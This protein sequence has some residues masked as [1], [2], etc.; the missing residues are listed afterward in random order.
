[1]LLEF[2]TRLALEN[3][4]FPQGDVS[5]CLVGVLK[6]AIMSELCGVTERADE[7]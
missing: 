6:A 1:M 5:G 3:V 7:S 2:R 4:G